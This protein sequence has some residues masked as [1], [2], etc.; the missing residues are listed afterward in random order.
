VSFDVNIQIVSAQNYTGFSFYSFGQTRSLGVR[1]INKLVNEVAKFLLTPVGSDPLN[2][3]Y[4]TQLTNLLGANVTLADSQEV[5]QLAVQQT[6]EAL[7]SYQAAE[8]AVPS[9]EQLASI[10]VTAFVLIPQ[11]PGIAAQI[12]ITNVANQSLQIILPMLTV[13]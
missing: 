13:T 9:D 12:L 3:N 8:T 5:L 11:A 7:Q 4:G 1:G 2:L 6:Q 10:S